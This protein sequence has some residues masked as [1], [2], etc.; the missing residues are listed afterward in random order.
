MTCDKLTQ[1]FSSGGLVTCDRRV[2]PKSYSTSGAGSGPQS[3]CTC[4]QCKAHNAK[5][6]KQPPWIKNAHEEAD[7]TRSSASVSRGRGAVISRGAGARMSTR[8]RGRFIPPSMRPADRLRSASPFI[9]VPV[10]ASSI[11]STGF[12][13]SVAIHL[14]P[15]E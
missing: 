7:I 3:L 14:N 13:T 5:G 12:Q 6:I 1:L 9:S 8:S 11:T 2:G 10:S 4:S 15:N